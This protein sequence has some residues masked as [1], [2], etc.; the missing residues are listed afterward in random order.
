V[1]RKQIGTMPEFLD[2]LADDAGAIREVAGEDKTEH[3]VPGA[4]SPTVQAEFREEAQGS[5]SGHSVNFRD[6][7]FF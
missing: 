4:R 2:H 6:S 5:R 7:L 3:I 1:C